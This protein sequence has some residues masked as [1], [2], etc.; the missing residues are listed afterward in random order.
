MVG[1][2]K[3]YLDR[4]R[5]RGSK[6]ISVII[7]PFLHFSLRDG[8]YLIGNYRVTVSTNYTDIRVGGD[9]V[10]VKDA[11]DGSFLLCIGD[12]TGHGIAKSPGALAC[13]A[14][15][16]GDGYEPAELLSGMNR[17]LCRLPISAGNTG[18]IAC[19]RFYPDGEIVYA[20]KI[21]DSVV[22]KDG[23]LVGVL[24]HK[25]PMLGVPE[26]DI[27]AERIHLADRETLSMCSDGY[28]DPLDDKTLVKVHFDPTHESLLDEDVQMRFPW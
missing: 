3:G 6:D 24:L 15:F 20:G 5:S 27:S 11:P 8:E 16:H 13:M 14:Y 25:G 28:K 1:S 9:F 19:F 2:I 4:A 21:E 12:I 22:H 18:F 7:E 10:C 17:L 26:I 23:N